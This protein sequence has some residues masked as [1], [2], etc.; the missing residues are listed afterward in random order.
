M[1]APAT[2][3]CSA[4]QPLAA[5][6]HPAIGE[7]KGMILIRVWNISVVLASHTE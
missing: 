7:G 6:A 4:Q 5:H 1:P 3:N 2:V